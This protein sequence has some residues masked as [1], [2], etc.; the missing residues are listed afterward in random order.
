MKTPAIPT[1]DLI[2]LAISSLLGVVLLFLMLASSE[3][4]LI[5]TLD[6][7]Y[8]HLALAENIAAGHY[9][10]NPQELSAPAS[11]IVWPFLLAPLT[12]SG[13]ADW[14]LLALN[15]GAVL[16][17][18]WLLL[19]SL[20]HFWPDAPRW[21]H[22]AGALLLVL[23]CNLWPLA[24]LGMEHSL[25]VALTVAALF[26]LS[27]LRPEA[28]P[29]GWL[30]VVVVVGPW[31]RYE[32]LALSLPIV[33]LLWW[34]GWRRGAILSGAVMLGGMAAFSLWLR[35]HDLGALPWSLTAKSRTLNSGG[36]SIQG[37]FNNL[38]HNLLAEPLGLLMAFILLV[39]VALG[40]RHPSR[41]PVLL[42]MVALVGLHLAFGRFGWFER[43]EL[44]AWSALLLLALWQS[45][46]ALNALLAHKGRRNGAILLVLGILL[47]SQ[48]PYP[49]AFYYSPAASGALYAQHRQ[50]AR[51]VHQY[52]GAAVAVNDLGMVAYQNDQYVLDFWGLGTPGIQE[53]SGQRPQQEWMLD[54]M[55]R[56]DIDLAIFYSEAFPDYPPSLIAVGVLRVSGATP[57]IYARE[58]RFFARDEATAARV[59]GLLI[60]WSRRLPARSRFSPAP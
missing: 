55:Q 38:R 2:V 44:Y 31:L 57:N 59:Q 33:A 56:Y 11:S 45:A 24:M 27:H 15:A 13:A 54:Y 43:Y 5:F 41:R 30:W 37:L 34:W 35:W 3:G 32:N 39:V 51:F 17:T 19:Q 36:L 40:W 47:L 53:A 12:L 8:I 7:A 23:L 48:T 25:Q 60:E 22:G 21:V 49:R 4:H 10:V 52:Y 18:T 46:A 42:V 16:L 1:L 14:L 28:P 29:P 6:D 50:V 20:R 26:G 58:V 9:G